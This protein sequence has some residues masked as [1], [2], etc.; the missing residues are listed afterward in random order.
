MQNS[1]FHSLGIGLIFILLATGF[2]SCKKDDDSSGTPTV[3]IQAADSVRA[4]PGINRIILSWKVEDPAVNKAVVYCDNGDSIAIPYGGSDTMSVTFPALE[5]GNYSFRIYLYDGEGHVSSLSKIVTRV[6]GDKYI[7]SLTS[8]SVLDALYDGGA[9]RIAWDRPGED[10]LGTEIRYLDV[11]GD[12]QYVFARPADDSAVLES[13]K[14]GT[15]FQYRTMYKPVPQAIDTFYAEYTSSEQWSTFYNPLLPDRG[16]D[17]WVAYKD[18]MYYFTY[19]QGG[20]VVLYATPKMSELRNA[21]A[22]TI[23]KAPSGTA[24]SH[25]IWAPEMHFIDHKWYVYF[26][27]DGGKDADHRLFVLENASPDPLRGTWE[28]KGELQ[29]PSDQWAI[30]GTVLEYSGQLYMIWSGKTNGTFP[31]DLYIAKMSNPYTLDGSRVMISTPD[32]YWEENGAAINE[33][34]EILKNKS[35]NVFLVYSGSGYWTDNY[36]LGMLSLKPGGDPLNPGDW[37]K[38]DQPLLQQSPAS[39]AYGTGHC[40]FF[41][42]RD[43]SE[44]WIIYHAR[45]YPNAGS[46]NPRNPRIQKITWNAD[47]TPDFGTPVKIN[48]K[49]QAPSG[50]F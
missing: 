23:W 20:S 32:H 9:V 26:A 48:E 37:T 3:T 21:S 43:G 36:C 14:P 41:K 12:T 5:G 19:T 15:Y 24:H 2:Y 25:D 31:Q 28:F 22:V 45:S 30:D 4:Y 39:G 42:S 7:R 49:I 10:M 1:I 11:S 29:E 35:G 6:Y 18:G 46:A 17:P 50:E 33:G 40:G 27:A 8:R 44:D 16:A 34:P 47:G 13:Y 38:S